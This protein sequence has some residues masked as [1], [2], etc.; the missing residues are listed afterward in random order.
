MNVHVDT[1]MRNVFLQETFNDF[2]VEWAADIFE[3]LPVVRDG[4]FTVSDAPGLGITVNEGDAETSY[5]EKNHMR[6][7]KSWL[8]SAVRRG[9]GG[10]VEGADPV[11]DPKALDNRRPL[12]IL[13]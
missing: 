8:G 4:Y 3:G 9:S 7:F 11:S 2:H 13:G 12:S 5:A 1:A 10:G 6:M